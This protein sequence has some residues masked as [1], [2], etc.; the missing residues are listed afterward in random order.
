MIRL[1]RFD[2]VEILLNVDQISQVE[3]TPTTVITLLNGEKIEVK[4]S[5]TDVVT[6]LKAARMGRLEDNRDPND[7][8]ESG[9]PFRKFPRR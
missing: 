8:P 2:G 6:K 7:A 5:E 9:K 1:F 3:S 4:N